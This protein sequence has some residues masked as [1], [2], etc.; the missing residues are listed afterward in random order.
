LVEGSSTLELVADEWPDFFDL[1]A[2]F[3]AAYG[4]AELQELYNQ[5]N[6]EASVAEGRIVPIDDADRVLLVQLGDEL[7]T[8]PGFPELQPD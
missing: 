8:Y 1:A 4:S 5:A 6:L 3:V 7:E 2:A